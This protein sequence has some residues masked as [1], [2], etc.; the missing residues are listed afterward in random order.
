LSLHA[1]RLVTLGRLALV[2]PGGQED[3]SLAKRRRKLALLAVLALYDVRTGRVLRL[4]TV[5]GPTLTLLADRAASSVLGLAEGSTGRPGFADVATSSI[6]A[7]QHYVR[8]LQAGA[9]GRFVDERRE[10]DAAIALDS[11]FAS[12]LRARSA[13]AL[14]TTDEPQ[15]AARLQER[16]RRSEE[17]GS[18][19]DRLAEAASSAL[20]SGNEKRAEHLAQ[21]LV[22]RYPGDPRAYDLLAELLTL[23]G[24]WTDADT[25]YRQEL[26]LDSLAMTAVEGP[27]IPCEAYNGLVS[28]RVGEGDLAGAEAVARRWTAL[29][30]DLP[31]AWS[32]LAFVLGAEQRYDAGWQRQPGRRRSRRRIRST[33]SASVACSSRRGATRRRIRS[34]RRSGW[35]G[36][37]PARRMTMRPTRSIYSSSA[38]ASVG[39]FGPPRGRSKQ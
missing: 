4:Y 22:A 3:E 2:G 14:Q 13:L 37:M 17:T 24:R 33:R 12:A 16:L 31:A 9:E 8:A 23:D 19:W 34:S 6:E 35:V 25:L 1:C 20:H 29:Q 27:C 26:S 10:L 36:R 38:S 7:Y 21:D 30:P 11:G 28:L 15:L 32:N 39:N 5:S 18:E